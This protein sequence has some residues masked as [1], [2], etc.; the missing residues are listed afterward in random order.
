[1]RGTINSDVSPATTS[2]AASERLDEPVWERLCRGMVFVRG[3]P[4][5]TALS[6]TI[7]S[8]KPSFSASSSIPGSSRRISPVASAAIAL[9]SMPISSQAAS[10]AKKR[11]SAVVPLRH[12]KPATIIALFLFCPNPLG[13]GHG[14]LPPLHGT[15]SCCP[16]DLNMDQIAAMPGMRCEEDGL[17]FKRHGIRNQSSPGFQVLYCR[18]QYSRIA[19]STTKK[20][21]IG[22]CQTMEGCRC[23]TL[24]NL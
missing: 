17:H 3:S 22:R 15:E 2:A 13:D 11:L 5:S 10:R 18:L 12:P 1:M 14:R 20:D 7:C 23:R 8:G 24:D 16:A 4:A 19:A 21:R 9:V 6:S